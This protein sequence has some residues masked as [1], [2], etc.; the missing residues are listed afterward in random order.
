MVILNQKVRPFTAKWHP[1]QE[2]GRLSARHD[3]FRRE[4]TDLQQ[5]LLVYT[6]ML[7]DMAGVEED[8]TALE[9]D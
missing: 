3:E 2:N 6:R 4:L 8:L 1:V 9:G 5:V 7:G